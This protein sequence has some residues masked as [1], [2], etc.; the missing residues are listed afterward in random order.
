MVTICGKALR[1]WLDCLACRPPKSL[2]TSGFAG[3]VLYQCV[4]FDL[5]SIHPI[6]VAVSIW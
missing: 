3:G 1:D 5:G 4:L 6:D 2:V